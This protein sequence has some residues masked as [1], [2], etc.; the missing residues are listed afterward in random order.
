MNCNKTD[1]PSGFSP[2]IW[3]A[4]HS[5]REFLPAVWGVNST[6]IRHS[7]CCVGQNTSE[8]LARRC[9]NTSVTIPVGKERENFCA[10]KHLFL[11]KI[12]ESSATKKVAK[13]P[14]KS[15]FQLETNVTSRKFRSPHTKD[16]G[17]CGFKITEFMQGQTF[18]EVV[19]Y[20]QKI[21]LGIV[22]C[23]RQL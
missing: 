2:K 16:C 19:C 9:A 23:S 4:A 21:Q 12:W 7:D 10:P 1:Y 18:W 3:P 5:V 15:F 17:S 13:T 22:S 20:T 6:V 8:H 11:E 14:Q